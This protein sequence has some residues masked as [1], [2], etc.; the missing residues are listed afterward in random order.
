MPSGVGE[1]ERF[2]LREWQRQFI[3]DVYEP[4]TQGGRRLVRRGILSIGRKNGKTALIAGLV[5]AHLVG[6]EA[7]RNGE[8]Y[9]AATEREQAGQVFKMAAQMIEAEPELA[10][11]LKVI[12]S[13]KR[14]VCYANGSFY[15]ALAA[16]AGSVHGLNPSVVIYDELAQAKD[17][18]LYD[19]L[20]TAMG[21]RKEPLFL[22]IS[23]QNANP[24]H[25]LS[26]LIDDGLSASDPTTVCHLYAVPDDADPWDESLW[27]LGNPALGDFRDLED[28]RTLAQQ[29]KRMPSKEPAFRNLYLNQRVSLVASLIRRE[30]WTACAAEGPL[31]V[32]GEPIWLGLDLSATTDLTALVAVSAEDG[33]RIAAWLWKPQD[34]LED[35]ARRDR[36]PYSDWARAGHL[37]V[38]PGRTVDYGLVVQVL[39]DLMARYDVL[40]VAYDRWR[41]DVL[42]KELDAEGIATWV[43]GRDRQTP[44]AL[45]LVPWGQGFRDMSPAIDALETA[46]LARTLRHPGNPALTWCVGNAVATLDP[47][48]NRKLDKSKS[49]MRIDGAVAM[50]MALG[51]KST[52]TVQRAEPSV[53]ETRG[54]LTL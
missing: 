32:E 49:R 22:A 26:E 29:A 45:R 4:Q 1:G 5:L 37:E 50:T 36:A 33:D 16:R 28:F 48:G 20:N 30:E 42:A 9:S 11:L 39:G 40:G 17:T 52:A 54:I 15:K 53:Y 23:T 46:V 47:A 41:A 6:P 24:D 44:G 13:V 31:L 51:L 21:A 2:R 8:I 35:H 14:I 18:E 3:R 34:S 43:D 10:R 25:V 19:A 38:S 7:I 27:H 12:P